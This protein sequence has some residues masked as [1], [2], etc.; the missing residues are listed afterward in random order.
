MFS[1]EEFFQNQN[2]KKNEQ[3]KKRKLENDQRILLNLLKQ[4][5]NKI[6]KEHKERCEG[7]ITP[8]ELKKT[9]RK[10]NKKKAPGIDG[11]PMEFYLKYDFLDNWLTEVLNEMIERERMTDSMR[12][13]T[14]KPFYK[15]GDRNKIEL[16]TNIPF[17]F[18]LQDTSKN[19]RRE[20]EPTLPSIM[21]KTNRGSYGRRHHRE[22]PPSQRDDR[23]LQR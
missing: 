6:T 20:N 12:T 8:L 4:I 1:N 17:V 5:K 18:R 13:A 2:S 3:E 23:V 22:Y 16:Q 21:G 11:I 15:K 7:K 19:N 14:I 10:M 9:K